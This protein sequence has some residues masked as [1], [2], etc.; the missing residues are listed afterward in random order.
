M[1]HLTEP[2]LL[3]V[4]DNGQQEPRINRPLV[5]ILADMVEY[6]LRKDSDGPTSAVESAPKATARRNGGSPT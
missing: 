4:S 2:V 1:K 5:K 3:P 6:A